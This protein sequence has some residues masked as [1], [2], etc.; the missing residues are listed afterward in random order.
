MRIM[1]TVSR[2]SG[3]HAREF[4]AAVVAAV[5]IAVGLPA[6]ASAFPAGGPAR[7][8]V[9][10]CA[11]SG[12]GSL[13]AVVT[14]A[15]PAS[16]VTF[17]V[18]CPSITLSSEI[19]LDRNVTIAGP[20]AALLAV[21]GGNTARHFVV[22]PSVKAAISGLTLRNGFAQEASQSGDGGSIFNFGD[23]ILRDVAL[24]D[25]A[26]DSSGGAIRNVSS[27]TVIRSVFSRN[28]GHYGGAIDNYSSDP[29]AT[30]ILVVDR[31]TFVANLATYGGAIANGL[32]M[33]V[34]V[35]GSTFTNNVA[36][37]DGEGSPDARGGAIVSEGLLRVSRS[38]FTGNESQFSGGAIRNGGTADVS[39]STLS[40]NSAITA[41]GAITNLGTMTVTRSEVTGNTATGTAP[42]AGL[43]GGISVSNYYPGDIGVLTLTDTRITGNSAPN[44]YGGGLFIGN[45]TLP[46]SATAF[47]C[48]FAANTDATTD[49]PAGVYV[50][51]GS[52]FSFKR[53]TFVG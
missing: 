3:R 14:T 48:L 6:A 35:A 34:R 23:L 18:S 25:N 12:P 8:V 5:A 37:D 52:S 2:G 15:P 17:S 29:S 27:L 31:S 36:V 21:D 53:S 47:R 10:N 33:S 28:A 26:A 13:R 16:V 51:P 43:G 4:M 44:G 19:P 24:S 22:A 11:D 40:G 32:G 30:V 41:G 39:D 42:D 20:G 7:R 45:Y 50:T 1:R 9:T 49:N 38:S 46:A